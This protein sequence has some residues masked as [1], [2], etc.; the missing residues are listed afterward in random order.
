MRIVSL[1]GGQLRLGP[2]T[3]TAVAVQLLLLLP[4]NLAETLPTLPLSSSH[5]VGRLAHLDLLVRRVRVSLPVSSPRPSPP[6]P[7]H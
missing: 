6:S 3:R 7:E 2:Q 1:R 5:S 4:P